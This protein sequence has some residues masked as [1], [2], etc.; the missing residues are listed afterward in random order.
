MMTHF[1]HDVDRIKHEQIFRQGYVQAYQYLSVPFLG[2]P[3]HILA[4][5]LITFGTNGACMI[6][7]LRNHLNFGILNEESVTFKMSS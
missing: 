7:Q 3:F 6:A 2:F 5:Q 4:G 1:P